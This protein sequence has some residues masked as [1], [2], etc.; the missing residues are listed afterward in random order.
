[1]VFSWIKKWRRRRIAE[2]AFP[3]GWLD[4]LEQNVSHYSLLAA[5]QQ[6]KLRRDTQVFVAEKNWEGCG[7]L[8]VTDEM[9]VT[10]AAQACLLVL[11][12]DATFSIPCCRS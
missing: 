2:A 6:Q 9:R 7:G 5:D 1:M 3:A 10:I 8:T 12:L 4:Y 11:A